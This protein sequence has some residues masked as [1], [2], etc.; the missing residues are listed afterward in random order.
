MTN[1]LH[2]QFEEYLTQNLPDYVEMLRQMV[3]I[4][5]FTA[6]PAGVDALGQLSALFLIWTPFFRPMKKFATISIGGWQATAF[7]ALVQSILRVAPC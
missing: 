4:N 3:A 2:V 6:N 1:P 7:T 5:S